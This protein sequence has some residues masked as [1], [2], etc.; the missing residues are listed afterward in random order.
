MRNRDREPQC[1]FCGEL[2]ERPQDIRTELGNVFSG[3]KCE[4][5]AVYV[6]DRSGHNLGE[7]YVDGLVFACDGDWETAWKL[8]PDID[9]KIESFYY[10]R[11]GHR[12]LD[13]VR[14]GSR[15]RENFLFIRLK[16]RAKE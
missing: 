10:D 8:T 1:P 16:S 9:Y 13:S 6:F 2:F 12:L 15:T 11:E 5:G 14:K 7:A 3:G 4:C